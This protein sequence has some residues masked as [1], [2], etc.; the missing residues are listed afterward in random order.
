MGW[1][2]SSSQPTDAH[3][4]HR[5]AGRHKAGGRAYLETLYGQICGSFDLGI[6]N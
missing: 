1:P 4:R 5:S 2:S 3:P 6:P